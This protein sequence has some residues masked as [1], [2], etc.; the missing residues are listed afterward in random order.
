MNGPD[1]Q[2]QWAQFR[3]LLFFR[4][5]FRGLWFLAVG[6]TWVFKSSNSGQT[7]S[8]FFEGLFVM[9]VFLLWLLIAILE[10]QVCYWPCPK[11]KRPYFLALFGLKPR[12]DLKRFTCPSCGLHSGLVAGSRTQSHST[13]AQ[14]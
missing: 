4:N 14:P 1:Y 12:T 9:T 7:Q 3:R 2:T 6:S 8:R 11:C 5:L 13:Q 10:L